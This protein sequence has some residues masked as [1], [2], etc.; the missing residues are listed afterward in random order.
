M[1]RLPLLLLPVLAV[2]APAQAGT[3][4]LGE[5][6]NEY[7]SG[8]SLVFRAAP[9]ERNDL[10]VVVTADRSVTVRDATATLTA[11]TGCRLLDARTARCAS[12]GR[13][14][15]IESGSVAL[16][17]GDDRVAATVPRAAGWG[18]LGLS[19]GAGADALDASAARNVADPKSSEGA[20]GIA[21]GAGNDRVTGSPGDDDLSGGAGD[22]SLAGGDGDD[23][24]LGDDDGSRTLGRDAVDGGPGRDTMS[25]EGRRTPVRVDL[26]RP[27]GAGASGEGDSLRAVENATGGRA[28]DVLLGDA[29]ANTLQG[30]ATLF[31]HRGAGDTLSGRG[32][33]DELLDFGGASRLSGGAGDDEL[34]GTD[35]RDALRCGGGRDKVTETEGTLVPRSC[36]RLV[37]DDHAYGPFVVRGGAAFVHVRT[38][39]RGAECRVTLTLRSKRRVVYGRAALRRTRRVRIPLTSAGRRAAARNRI[40]VVDAFERC[41]DTHDR[42]RVRL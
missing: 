15:A 17:D 9:G 2:P 22:D 4:S 35:A 20:V 24:L 29:R 33:N 38:V 36:D 39:A 27:A 5:P 25:Y 23:L 19:G 11:G 30:S 34:A 10:T 41:A 28:R 18:A 7:F 6:H 8:P 14:G 26:A 31:P 37:T 16:G 42:W 3:V 13:D 32:G 12:G 1:R 40:A 21:G